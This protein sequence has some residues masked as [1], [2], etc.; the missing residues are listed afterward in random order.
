MDSYDPQQT[1]GLQGLPATS[2]NVFD[3][4][5]GILR[6]IGFAIALTLIAIGLVLCFRTYG[7]VRDLVESP[8]QLLVYLDSWEDHKQVPVDVPVDAP[9]AEASEVSESTESLEEEAEAAAPARQRS[10]ARRSRRSAPSDAEKIKDVFDFMDRVVKMLDAGGLSRVIGGGIIFLFSM[11]L[12]WISLV[13]LKTGVGLLIGTIGQPKV[14]Y[15][16]V[17]K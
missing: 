6:L 10:A 2:G 17:R 8:E 12:A 11:V 3:S 15:T 13:I 16:G 1:Q 5:L 7:I 9:D 4:V 14:V